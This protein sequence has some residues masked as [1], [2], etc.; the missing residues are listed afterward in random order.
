SPGAGH[1]LVGMRERAAMLGGE[2]LAGPA[3]DGGYEVAAELPV[4][5]GEPA[6]EG[7]DE[8]TDGTRGTGGYGDTTG[9]SGT[10]GTRHRKN[11]DSSV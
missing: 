4:P 7:G 1:G 9:T 2:L 5:P 6:H 8:G 3:P 10:T 11:E